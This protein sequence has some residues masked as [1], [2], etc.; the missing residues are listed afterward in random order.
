[1]GEPGAGAVIMMWAP[2]LEA[3]QR[4]SKL[5]WANHLTMLSPILYNGDGFGT[6][7][8]KPDDRRLRAKQTRSQLQCK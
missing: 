4:R 7:W 2:A 1:M 3:A 8:A 5:A 6:A